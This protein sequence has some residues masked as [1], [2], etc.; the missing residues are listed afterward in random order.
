MRRYVY[1]LSAVTLALSACGP[2]AGEEAALAAE[3]A[4]VGEAA[5]EVLVIRPV[6]TPVAQVYQPPQPALLDL[7]TTRI[8]PTRFI[9]S[10]VKSS[11]T[12]IY[13]FPGDPGTFYAFGFDVK[14]YTTVFM[15]RGQS[16]QKAAFKSEIDADLRALSYEAALGLSTGYEGGRQIDVPT[17]PSP[18]P[19]IN[20]LLA[21]AWDES[22][23]QYMADVAQPIIYMPSAVLYL[24][25]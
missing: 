6:F 19:N 23:Y 22:K 15:V 20:D 2:E 1:L 9:P 10:T 3:Q 17:P 13:N 11:Y 16:T 7:S 12:V 8:W 14:N 24:Q 4:P 25:P 21:K 18:T 5:Q